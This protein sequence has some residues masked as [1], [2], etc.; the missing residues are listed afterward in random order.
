MIIAKDYLEKI[1]T[2]F[3]FSEK[4]SF[5]Q[6]ATVSK[7]GDTYEPKM[8]TVMMYYE[9]EREAFYFTCSTQTH[10]WAELKVIP[11]VTGL[12]FDREN[13][14]QYRFEATAA[15]ID[16]QTKNEKKLFEETWLNLRPDLRHVLW[17]EYLKDKSKNYNIDTILPAHG[18]VVLQP[19]YWDIFALGIPNY[20]T[21]SRTQMILNDKEEWKVY[22]NAPKI[23]P[24]DLSP[25]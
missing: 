11:K 1:E 13:F 25:Y 20:E 19:Y 12:Y 8:R 14:T 17:Q 9:K 7:S 24:L 5:C 21:S 2:V 3:K 4:R 10:K 23:C 6:I 16:F 15:L 22:E 18:I